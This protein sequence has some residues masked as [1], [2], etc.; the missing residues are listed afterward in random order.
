MLIELNEFFEKCHIFL[1]HSV[2]CATKLSLETTVKDLVINHST[3][4]SDKA[5]ASAPSSD[6][7]QQSGG[8]AKEKN[9]KHT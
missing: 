9:P 6:K 3:T 8:F 5:Q 1:I 7:T 4:K 2:V